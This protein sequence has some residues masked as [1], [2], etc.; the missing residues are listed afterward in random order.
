[1]EAILHTFGIDWRLLLIQGINF[2]LLLAGLTYFL[3]KP[4]MRMLEERRATVAAGVQNAE[5][6]RAELEQIERARAEKLAHAGRE[7]DEV[8]SSARSAAVK[9]E[10]EIVAHAESTAATL[11]RDAEAQ[12]KEAKTQAIEESKEEVA[13]LIVL[14]ME[15]AL[16][17]K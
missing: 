11:L 12:A 4:L 5:R 16:L 7:A 10:R 3:Y 17:R 9:R 2:G 8:L 13:R 6:A 1:M 15:K 14:G